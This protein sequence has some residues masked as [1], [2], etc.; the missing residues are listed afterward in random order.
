MS[1]NVTLQYPATDFTQKELAT[2]NGKSNQ[3]VWT[4]MQN[5]LADGTFIRVPARPTVAG[6]KGK[7]AQQYRFVPNPADRVPLITAA[8]PSIQKKIAEAAA[9]ALAAA[10]AAAPVVVATVAPA[11]DATAAPAPTADA[12][13]A[14]VENVVATPVAD[15]TPAPVIEAIVPVV[16]I[17]PAT[18]AVETPAPVIEA[19]VEVA[20]VE[21]AVAPEPEAAT[22]EVLRVEPTPEPIKTVADET[23]TT[24]TP[25]PSCGHNLSA[26]A[27]GDGYTVWCS[28]GNE[29]C[30]IPDISQHSDTVAHATAELVEKWNRLLGKREVVAA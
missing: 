18:P 15:A 25:C 1:K 9:A 6:K 17:E 30:P 23:I 13:P 11:A 21:A 5:N 16:A 3:Q 27:V 4:T 26:V 22:V 29:V 8:V 24:D 10:A 12:T 2:I 7:P 14:P 19:V 20:P 28:Q